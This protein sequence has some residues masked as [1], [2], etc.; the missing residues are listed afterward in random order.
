MIARSGGKGDVSLGPLPHYFPLAEKARESWD[1]FYTDKFV[2][3][4]EIL[5]GNDNPLFLISKANIYPR[6]WIEAHYSMFEGERYSHYCAIIECLTFYD[7]S[8]VGGHAQDFI[9]NGRVAGDASMFVE[10]PER[11]K[12]P[13]VSGLVSVPA[14]VWL[15]RLHDG[16]CLFRDSVSGFCDV[17]LC[18]KG[19][20]FFN[21]ET[22]SP[23]R[24]PVDL[25]CKRPSQMIQRGSHIVNEISRNQAKCEK[26][27][28]VKR[29]SFDYEV[30]GFQ[31]LVTRNSI[32]LLGMTAVTPDRPPE[33][34]KV[35]LRPTHFQVGCQNGHGRSIAEPVLDLK[36]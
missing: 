25:Q 34:I 1:Y 14:I 17:D 10:I 33:N 5:E 29:L 4:P 8:H 26:S 31:I 9:A 18:V 21:R 24:L 22:Y 13:E 20:L 2:Y 36:G 32:N 7:G 23:R 11:V 27:V 16:D 28:F 6:I 3:V 19:I 12:S 30:P 15:K 35:F